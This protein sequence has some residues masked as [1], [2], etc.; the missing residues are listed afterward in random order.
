MTGPEIAEKTGLTPNSVR[1][2]LHRGMRALRQKLE[3]IIGEE[4]AD[5]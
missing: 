2:N 4:V 5:E 1:I 3:L